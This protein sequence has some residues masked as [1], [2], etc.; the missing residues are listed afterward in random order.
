MVAIRDYSDCIKYHTLTDEE[1]A[2]CKMSARLPVLAEMA[3]DKMLDII[4]CLS[5]TAP[6]DSSSAI[7]SFK[8]L[9]T[10]EGDEEK[11]LKKAINRCVAAIF[12]NADDPVTSKLGR[13]MLQFVKTNQFESSLATD[14]IASMM[15]SMTY[16]L[17]SI[18][19]SF[20]E[21]VLRNLRI[22]LT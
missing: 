15:A 16:E 9:A 4:Q 13:K 6:K 3:L 17:P 8:D 14:M 19:I 21:H 11:V 18:W 22:V 20:A 10:K 5:V 12:K 7:G 2:L 1:K